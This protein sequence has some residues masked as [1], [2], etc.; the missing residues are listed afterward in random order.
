MRAPV[1]DQ[2]H[3]MGA[4]AAAQPCCLLERKQSSPR[5][6]S[7]RHPEDTERRDDVLGQA[8]GRRPS[9]DTAPKHLCAYVPCTY[10]GKCGVLMLWLT[11]WTAHAFK[12][13]QIYARRA[14]TYVF[15][16]VCAHEACPCALLC[17]W[18]KRIHVCAWGICVCAVYVYINVY[19]HIN[20]MCACV[21]A[22]DMYTHLHI[23]V[24]RPHVSVHTCDSCTLYSAAPSR[25]SPVN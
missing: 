2:P 13:M 24:H 3:S 23:S 12:P 5:S 19:V 6:G 22:R 16:Y 17:A 18:G 8:Q 10:L 15:I 7:D 14:C 9:A 21:C 20:Y 1:W 11:A 25:H 4:P